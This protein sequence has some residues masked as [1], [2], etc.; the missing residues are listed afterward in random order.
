MC[1]SE[2]A[3]CRIS[4]GLSISRSRNSPEKLFSL[5]AFSRLHPA[6]FGS[7]CFR[8][9]RHGES[10]WEGGDSPDRRHRA[11]WRPAGVFLGLKCELGLLTHLVCRCKNRILGR[12]SV[13]TTY[14]LRCLAYDRVPIRVVGAVSNRP[15]RIKPQ[16]PT[17]IG[18]LMESHIV[19]LR[20]PSQVRYHPG[21]VH[22]PATL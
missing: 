2:R 9:R 7:R 22:R 8:I 20:S 5:P 10:F 12:T 17:D 14:M 4:H 15:I 16:P 19:W 6:R 18:L 11:K 3:E 13:A 1:T 21:L